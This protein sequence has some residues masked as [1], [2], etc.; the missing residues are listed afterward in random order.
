MESRSRLIQCRLNECNGLISQV[1]TGWQCRVC[2]RVYLGQMPTVNLMANNFALILLQ[3]KYFFAHK[4]ITSCLKGSYYE[5][6]TFLVFNVT[7]FCVTS[8]LTNTPSAIDYKVHICRWDEICVTETDRSEL[9][10]LSSRLAKNI[11]RFFFRIWAR[12]QCIRGSSR[13]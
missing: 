10:W 13:C 4:N 1:A 5:W 2:V 7:F 11:H 8:M 6:Q 12:H 9:A 3:K